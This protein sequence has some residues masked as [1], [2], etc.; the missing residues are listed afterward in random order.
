LKEQPASITV[1]S[2]EDKSSTV[3]FGGE[4]VIKNSGASES[5]FFQQPHTNPVF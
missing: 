1:A 4:T 2:N 5:L 3:D